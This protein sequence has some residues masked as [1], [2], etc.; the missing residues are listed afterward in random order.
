MV[1]ISITKRTTIYQWLM[2]SDE[3][4]KE[5]KKVLKKTYESLNPLQLKQELDKAETELF[6]LNKE[7]K[8]KTKTNIKK[9]FSVSSLIAQHPNFRCTT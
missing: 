9:P 3:I 7:K 4:S 6:K 5:Q 1:I 2:E 8:M